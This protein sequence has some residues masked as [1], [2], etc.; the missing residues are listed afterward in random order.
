MFLTAAELVTLTGYR[1]PSKQI[2]W[3]RGRRDITF[4][5]NGLGHP[6]VARDALT[7]KGAARPR[8][9]PRLHLVK[10]A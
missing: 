4:W 5:I 6:V 8:P 3:L 7:G 10:V 1:R 2:A 9:A